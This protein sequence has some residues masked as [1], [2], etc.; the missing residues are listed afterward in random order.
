MKVPQYM[1]QAANLGNMGAKNRSGHIF[2]H[3]SYGVK[4]DLAKAFSFYDEA[5]TQG[6][7]LN[8]ML[9]LSR[10]YNG[11][12]HGPDDHD[13]MLRRA[14]DGSGW[15]LSHPKDEDRSFYWCKRAAQGGL[16]EALY[17]LG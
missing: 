17:L 9:G 6:N 4:M 16:P 14:N 3:G 11:G 12:S 2:E 7:H 8:A 15:L 5:A 13:E 1:E 10:L